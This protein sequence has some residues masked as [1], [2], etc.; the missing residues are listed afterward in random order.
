MEKKYK[1]DIKFFRLPYGSG[2]DVPVVREVIAKNKLIN[3]FWNVDSLDWIPQSPDRIVKRTRELMRKTP[4]DAG[5]IL[6]HDVH[7]RSVTASGSIMDVL[8][9]DSRRVC[10]L[11]EIVDDLNEGKGQVCSS[12]FF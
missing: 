4:R 11:G 9:S 2:I 7:Q 10:T 3:T 12:S 5:I 8:K 6:F 1:V